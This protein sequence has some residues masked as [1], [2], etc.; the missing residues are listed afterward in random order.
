MRRMVEHFRGGVSVLKLQSTSTSDQA[1]H[2][3]A[4]RDLLFRKRTPLEVKS[5]LHHTS[6]ASFHI[7]SKPA[8][9]LKLVNLLD[10]AALLRASHVRD[11]FA[12]C[13]LA[14]EFHVVPKLQLA[15]ELW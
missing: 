12:E 14:G 1:R 10:K 6:D 15:A 2:G 9:L 11:N 13:F 4:S 7:Y 3:G 8:R 5:R